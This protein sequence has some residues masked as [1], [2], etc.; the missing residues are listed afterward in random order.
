MTY[1][2]DYFIN[3]F[4]AIPEDKWIRLRL[5]HEDTGAC[6]ANGHCGVRAEGHITEEY[7]EEA[8]ELQKVLAPLPV[9]YTNGDPIEDAGNYSKKAAYINN[10]IAKEYIQ[11][12]P[13][14][15]IL[16]ALYDIKKMQSKDIDT[17]GKAEPKERIVYVSVPVSITEQAKELITN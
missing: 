7:P 13:K 1:D 5:Y 14:Q 10:G 2:V 6:C 16:A 4:Q 15:R 11:E 12:T 17:G 8:K 3:K 9:H